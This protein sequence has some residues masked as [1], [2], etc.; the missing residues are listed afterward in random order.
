MA[1]DHVEGPVPVLVADVEQIREAGHPDDVDYAVN[2]AERLGGLG[3]HPLDGRALAGITRPRK[4]PHLARHPGGALGLEVDAEHARPDR[5]ERVRRL[6]ADSLSRPDHHEAAPIEAEQRRVV[7]DGVLVGLGHHPS[8]GTN[9]GAITS[10]ST[11]GKRSGRKTARRGM[12]K[13]SASGTQSTRLVARRTAGSSS[14]ATSAATKGTLRAK[15]GRKARRTT[16]HEKSRP[17][18]LIRVHANPPSPHRRHRATGY[19]A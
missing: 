1:E 4:A 14:S 10:R 9:I 13:S 6:P 7:G 19:Q 15:A 8:A 12:S 18:P 2:P 17:R 3:D 11:P 5:G 16:T